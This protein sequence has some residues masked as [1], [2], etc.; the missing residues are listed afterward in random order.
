M[1]QVDISCG[2]FIKG[3]VLILLA[4]KVKDGPFGGIEAC[5]VKIEYY[6]V[7]VMHS[8]NALLPYIA[9]QPKMMALE[10]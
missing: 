2:L 3:T 4:P 6:I 5:S 9:R 8:V 1:E 10:A 7:C